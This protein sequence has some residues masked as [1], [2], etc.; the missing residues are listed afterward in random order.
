MNSVF[1][2]LFSIQIICAKIGSISSTPLS[3]FSLVLIYVYLLIP[4]H[5]F[6]YHHTSI[7]VCPYIYPCMPHASIRSS[8]LV[9][10]SI[11]STRL[12]VCSSVYLSMS[13]SCPYIQSISNLLKCY[14]HVV[15]ID[16]LDISNRESLPNTDYNVC[17]IIYLNISYSN[18]G[19]CVNY[20]WYSPRHLH[21]KQSPPYLLRPTEH[22]L[23]H[24]TLPTLYHHGHQQEKVH[25][26]PS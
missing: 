22:Y 14:V 20:H 9:Y 19:C 13:H 18:N 23:H 21:Q 4:V 3:M 17:H 16:F 7:H 24:H 15:N 1:I 8:V 5:I 6:T 12:S 11:R 10:P 26:G 25:S 2:N